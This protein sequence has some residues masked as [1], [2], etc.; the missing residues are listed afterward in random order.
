MQC[1]ALINHTDLYVDLD[2]ASWLGLTGN[3]RLHVP[4]CPRALLLL[5]YTTGTILQCIIGNGRSSS[6]F[7]LRTRTAQHA[8]AMHA[9]AIY[10]CMR[11]VLVHAHI[12]VA[13]VTCSIS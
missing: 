4:N 11:I 9:H 2:E 6:M 5:Y 13:H 7:Q 1:K 12:L 8:C 3:P 10:A